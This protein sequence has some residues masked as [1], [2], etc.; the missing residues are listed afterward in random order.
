MVLIY[1]NEFRRLLVLLFDHVCDEIL[2]RIDS[3]VGTL[4]PIQKPHAFQDTLVDAVENAEVP[5]L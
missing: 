4:A 2:P 5:D 1:E 3:D